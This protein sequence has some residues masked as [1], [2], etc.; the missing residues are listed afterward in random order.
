MSESKVETSFKSRA[1]N[2]R[3]PWLLRA[4]LWIVAKSETQKIFDTSVKKLKT[5]SVK[6]ATYLRDAPLLR[7]L[8][9]LCRRGP[10][11]R[12]EAAEDALE[13]SRVR[14]LPKLPTR[15]SLRKIRVFFL[16]GRK[17]PSLL[18]VRGE[19]RAWKEASPLPR[20]PHLVARSVLVGR[21]DRR[22]VLDHA[23]RDHVFEEPAWIRDVFFERHLFQK[24]LSLSLSLSLS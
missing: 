18:K 14:H 12:R 11:R 22:E 3:S 2:A 10:R 24:A 15:S 4:V 8:R 16:S 17:R 6:N 9:E 19:E 20:A 7:G 23:R 21:R 1:Q 5:N 13:A